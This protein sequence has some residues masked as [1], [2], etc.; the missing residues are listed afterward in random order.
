[1]AV[2]VYCSDS[3][4]GNHPDEF[5]RPHLGLPRYDRLALPGGPAWQSRRSSTGLS[6]HG[7]VSDQMTPSYR[8]TTCAAPC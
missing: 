6:H 3:R 4:Y 8:R 5:L 1:M 2:A 7:L